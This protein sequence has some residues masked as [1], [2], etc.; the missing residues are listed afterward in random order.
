MTGPRDPWL[1][2][3][4]AYTKG[5]RERER[6]SMALLTLAEYGEGTPCQDQSMGHLWLSE[7]PQDRGVAI[8][9]CGACPLTGALGVCGAAAVAGHASWGVWAGRDHTP[10]VSPRGRGRPRS[11]V[12]TDVDTPVDRVA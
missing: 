11:T 7:V 3:A 2:L 9:L 6:L 8:K 1:Q 12:D 4:T 10:P 5:N